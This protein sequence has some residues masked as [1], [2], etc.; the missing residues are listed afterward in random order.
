MVRK[1]ITAISIALAFS[2]AFAQSLKVEKYTL[3]NGLTVIFN[4]D[5]RVP[6]VVVNLWYKVGSKDEAPKRS[7]FAHL[8]EHLMFMGTERAPNGQFDKI[9]EAEGGSNNASTWFDRTNYFE[10]GPS[11]LLPVFLWLEAD[12]MEML[13]K[14]M[15]KEKLDLQRDVVRNERRQNVENQPYGEAETKIPELMYPEGHPYHIDVIGKHEDLE[16]ASV[17]DVKNF[18]ATFY[19]P[20][21]CSLTIVGDF[22]SAAAKKMIAEMFSGIG[23]QNDPIHRQAEPVKLPGVT[24]LTMVDKAPAPRIY[25]VF[26]SPASYSEGDAEMQL[27]GSILG[28]GVSSRLY[29]RLVS[30]KGLASDVSASQTSLILGSMFQVTLTASPGADLDKLQSEAEAVL[31]EFKAKGPTQAEIDRQRAQ[32]KNGLAS[33]VASF[34]QRA[35]ALNSYEFSYGEPNSFKRD[36]DRYS[37]VSPASIRTTS[38]K[39]LDLDRRVILTVLPKPE[40]KL[41]TNPLDKQPKVLADRPATF[42]T[43]SDFTL[44]NGVKVH[45]IPRTDVPL[46]NVAAS[47]PFSNRNEDAAKRGVTYLTTAMLERGS[48]SLNAQQF[49]EALQRLGASVNFNSNGNGL[50]ANLDVL[51]ENAKDALALFGKALTKPRFDKDEWERLVSEHKANLLRAESTSSRVADAALSKALFVSGAASLPGSGTTETISKISLADA[52]AQYAKIKSQPL[53]LFV[54]GNISQKDLEESLNQ[55]LQDWKG[56]SATPAPSYAL[57]ESSAK[58]LIIDNPGAPQTS[59]RI[60]FPEITV[61]SDKRLATEA[62]QIVIGGSFTSRLNQ[63]LREKN[64]YTYGAG[65]RLSQDSQVGYGTVRTEVRTDVTGASLKEI[66]AELGS[67]SS[68]NITPEEHGKAISTSKNG[69]VETLDSLNSITANLASLVQLGLSINQLGMDY[70]ALS[71]VTLS[72]LNNEA[73]TMFPMNKAIIVLVGD[74]AKILEQIKG[75]P[76][77]EPTFLGKIAGAKS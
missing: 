43:T 77:P 75:L 61:K 56:E 51:S 42:P 19:V 4:E 50:N 48:G 8:F 64:G 45:F 63:N 23:R 44:K 18:F 25:M 11:R 29:Q 58:L 7:G 39:T 70:T 24:K 13:G 53:E 49:E 69:L 76:L 3:P 9:M 10:S 2:S 22:D 31:Q 57:V 33:Q 47:I 71:K 68:G 28:S 17:D 21:N 6:K 59:V 72:D 62:V 34:D 73:K 38:A 67:I 65:F 40:G 35:D 14:A 20:N 36:M 12:R 41:A 66:L 55:S 32:I 30:E 46:L 5:H 74:K 37:K 52:Q 26:H 60:A 27:A 54:S 15:T 16:A 1:G